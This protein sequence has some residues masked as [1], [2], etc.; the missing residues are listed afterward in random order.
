MRLFRFSVIA[1]FACL[2]TA[3]LG[4]C[5]DDEG[6]DNREK[7]YGY[8]QFKLYKEA[9]YQAAQP[10]VAAESRAVKPQLDYLAEASKVKVTLS[11]GATTIAQT[12]T[13]SAADKDAAEY[14]LRSEKFKLLTGE[15]EV[16]T[17]ALYDANDE[18]IYNGVP[19][20]DSKILIVAGGLTSHDLTVDTQ[21][22]GKVKFSLVKDIKTDFPDNPNPPRTPETRAV[23]RQYTFDEIKTFS[24]TVQNKG[25]NEQTT[26]EK[27]EMEFSIHFDDDPDTT[28]YQTSSS[29]C[30]SLLSLPAGEY[31]VLSY[32]TYDSNKMLLETNSRP[33]TT[34][35][36]V[37]DN[38][39]TEV[40]TQITLYESDEYVKDAYALYEIWTALDGPNWYYYGENFPA[41]TNWDFN[42]DPDLW[43]EQ[44]GVEV[45]SNGRVAKISIGDFGFRGHMPAALGQ[46]TQLVELYLGS[47]N[48]GN[49]LEYD[50][51]LSTDQTL[52][53]RSRN[54]MSNHKKYLS[55]IH[56]ATQ[57]SEPCA[58]AL[59]LHNIQIPA[60]S[61]YNEGFEE[62]EI[63]E[64]GTGQQKRIRPMDMVHGKLTNGLK[65][66]P[67]EIG[68]LKNLEYLFIAN[69]ELT[70]LPDEVAGLESC[71]D[72]EL[73]NC[74]KMTKFPLALAQMPKIVSLNISNNSQWSAEEIYKGLDALASGPSKEVIQI[75]YSRDNKLEE[76]PESFSNLKKIGLLDLS[77]NKIRTL[78]PFGKE[79]A[80]V[81]LFLDNN[82]IEEI[83]VNS[84]GVFCNMDD[85]ESLSMTFNKLKEFPNIFTSKTKFT[86]KSV[87]FSNNQITGFPADFK[88]INV[89]TL[90]LAVNP[91]TKFPK[92]LGETNSMVSYI[93]LRGC[94]VDE[95]PEGSFKGKYSSS[96][97]SLDLTYNK[98]TKFPKDFT[99]EDLPYLYG[100]DISYNAF[101]EFPKSPLNCS[102]LTVYALRGQRD[103]N[104]GRC[105]KEWPTGIYQHTGLRGLYLGSNDL[106]KIDDTISYL[107][108][109]LDISDNPNITFDAS[110]VCYYWK[111]GVYN[112][113][114]DKTQNIINCDQMLE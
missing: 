69:G 114:Y 9:S 84:E 67:K 65:S 47:H 54:R 100:L 35:F 97:I 21:P 41:G 19:Q 104:G 77:G 33:K 3:F 31:R 89:E 103:A 7:D 86:M 13:L 5:S 26:F 45:H 102:G 28:D 48:D 108:F 20:H 14:G 87:D 70:E 51:S 18:L 94:Q 46:L 71:T 75:L 1:A 34:E 60:T 4:G 72:I 63:I 107:I 88:G 99:A 66:L 78:H 101:G 16:V 105:L 57:L 29:K 36:S 64:P 62:D 85:I 22:R 40:K 56:P 93:I 42:K 32:Q 24:V 15:Y 6:I 2:A 10:A 76:V 96:M 58:F 59:R 111:Q 38:Q 68:N 53:E 50:P 113:V 73:Y 95:I 83:P 79:V 91:I 37:T 27:L 109:H 39:T 43:Y 74:P 25:T 61:L 30:D 98:L 82:Q 11:F 44:P 52:T 110:G 112:L 49:S 92:C 23:D 106:R 90:T 55:L 17:F 8:L 12:L 80:P 81:Q